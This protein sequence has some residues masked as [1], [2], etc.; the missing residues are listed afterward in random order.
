[1]EELT[2]KKANKTG[3]F[4]SAATVNGGNL[5]ITLTRVYSNNFEKA[6]DWPKM[7]EL[8]DMAS[9]FNSKKVLFEKKG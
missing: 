1:M 9:D 4:S 8:M 5:V 7:V 6:T 2:V 3:S